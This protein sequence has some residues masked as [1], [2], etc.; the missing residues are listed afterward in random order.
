MEEICEYCIWHNHEGYCDQDES[1]R[2]G[3]IISDDDTCEHC[4]TL[5]SL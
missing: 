4:E 5:E 3:E 2:Y 1:P